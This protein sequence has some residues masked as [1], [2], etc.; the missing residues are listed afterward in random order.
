MQLLALAVDGFGELT[1]KG[2]IGHNLFDF[3][4][5]LRCSDRILNRNP[6]LLI[7]LQR[8]HFHA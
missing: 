2:R 7:G 6:D 4:L 8:H 5:V 3:L 1:G